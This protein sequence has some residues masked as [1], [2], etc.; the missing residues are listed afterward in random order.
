MDNPTPL[1]PSAPEA[2]AEQLSPGARR[3]AL[4]SLSLLVIA[5]WAG[6]GVRFGFSRSAIAVLVFLGMVWFGSRQIRSMVS[7]PPEPELADV[8]DYGLKYVCTMCGLELKVEVAARDKPPTHCMEPM[9]LERTGGKP[10][11]RPVD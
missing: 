10:P 6:L 5:V 4:V 1:T 7:V 9:K 8:S 3:T 11:L 2:E